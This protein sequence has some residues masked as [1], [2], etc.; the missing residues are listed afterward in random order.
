MNPRTIAERARVAPIFQRPALSLIS[1]GHGPDRASLFIGGTEAARDLAALDAAGISTVV[2]CAVNLDINYVRDPAFAAAPGKC[3]AGPGAVR[4]YKIG[5]IDG[6]GNPRQM[7]LAGYYILDGALTQTMPDKAS[8]PHRT[9]GHV[10][11]HCRGGRSRSVAL[12]ALYLH[13]QEPERYPRLDDAIAHVRRR[14]E[15]REEEWHETPKPVLVE[16]ARY[17][18]AAIR[19]LD[20][21]S[22]H[23]PAEPECRPA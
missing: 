14:R 17:A 21:T 8:Y 15:L 13:C 11:V 1:E 2:N 16:A 23:A 6:D 18:A 20:E 5:L 10:L 4:S 7:L 3:A 12:V 19:L 9:R 22:L